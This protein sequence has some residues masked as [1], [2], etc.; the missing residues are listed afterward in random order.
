[1]ALQFQKPPSTLSERGRAWVRIELRSREHLALAVAA[2]DSPIADFLP[3]EVEVPAAAT[4]QL[5]PNSDSANGLIETARANP[6]P[7]T[8]ARSMDS[9][10]TLP[11]G[12]AVTHERA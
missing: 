10:P 12:E 8:L 6:G 9:T 7:D 2:T 11:S 1:M 3:P 5:G 4:F